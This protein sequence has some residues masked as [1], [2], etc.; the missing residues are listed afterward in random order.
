MRVG[1]DGTPSLL[2]SDSSTFIELPNALPY[3]G[4]LCRLLKVGKKAKIR[5]RYNQVPYL[6]QDAVW[7]SDNS[8]TGESRNQLF[9][10]PAG[11][12]KAA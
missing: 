6:T 11:D 1:T 5:N 2:M 4:D 7:E 10:F 12:H 3:S 9:N 8:H